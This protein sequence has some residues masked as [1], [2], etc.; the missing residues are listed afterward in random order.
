MESFENQTRKS[1]VYSDDA[2]TVSPALSDFDPYGPAYTTSSSHDR[3]HFTPNS[4]FSKNAYSDMSTPCDSIWRPSTEQS[5]DVSFDIEDMVLTTADSTISMAKKPSTIDSYLSPLSL[6][7]YL[8][9]PKI[10]ASSEPSDGSVN[11]E[12]LSNATEALAHNVVESLFDNS[13]EQPDDFPQVHSSKHVSSSD[14][15][16]AAPVK[17]P[18]E[19]VRPDGQEPKVDQV[20]RT[21]PGEDVVDSWEE[22]DSDDFIP[23]LAEVQ[24]ALNNVSI[25]NQQK[26]KVETAESS[27]S[28]K[29]NVSDLNHVLEAFQLN[30]RIR[31]EA[32]EAALEGD[33]KVIRVDESHAFVVFPSVH[34]AMNA[35]VT[36][37][38]PIIKLRPLGEASA[39][40]L[41]KVDSCRSQLGL[42]RF[43]PQ[44]NASVARR[45]IEHSLGKRSTTSTEKRLKERQ[46]LKEARELKNQIAGIWDD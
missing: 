29:Y 45:L 14:R 2:Q 42:P 3:S 21:V 40:S 39:A 28:C 5:G 25:K 43:R 8:T 15:T 26:A 31:T 35:L 36:K 11:D 27:K 1:H 19:P 30:T 4:G 6:N 13:T 38:H 32:V 41:K 12:Q 37:Q 17:C 20:E 33:A 23:K 7:A 24:S 46:Q 34:L 22:L 10:G 44:T 9:A 16:A 18:T